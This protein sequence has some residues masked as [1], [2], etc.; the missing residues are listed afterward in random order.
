[1]KPELHL[2][3]ENEVLSPASQQGCGGS[4]SF[5]LSKVGILHVII[6]CSSKGEENY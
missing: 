5:L 4:Q 1:M 6:K 3:T 2:E